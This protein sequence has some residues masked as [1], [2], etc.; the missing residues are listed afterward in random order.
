M[1]RRHEIGRAISACGAVKAV[2]CLR[3]MA[4]GFRNAAESSYWQKWVNLGAR[5]EAAASWM[6]KEAWFTRRKGLLNTYK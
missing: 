4:P 3:G 2:V 1:P 5:G 6:V